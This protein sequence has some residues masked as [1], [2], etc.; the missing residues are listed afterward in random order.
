MTCL[1]IQLYEALRDAPSN[2]LME[3]VLKST[4]DILSQLLNHEILLASSA[5]K[6]S[7]LDIE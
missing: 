7:L 6:K 4:S 3:A 2:H 1:S 5:Q